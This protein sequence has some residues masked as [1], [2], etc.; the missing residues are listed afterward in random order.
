MRA[1]LTFPK[2]FGMKST[3][4]EI[5]AM[6][7][8]ILYPKAS[9][10][11]YHH[12]KFRRGIVN[13]TVRCSAKKPYLKN[14]LRKHLCWSLFLIKCKFIKK[15]LQYMCFLDSNSENFKNSYFE[16]HL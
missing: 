10:R 15:T 16:E 2:N 8:A 4:E 5:K 13:R 12:I 3:M 9:K 11:F 14:F 1:E 7:Q 6:A